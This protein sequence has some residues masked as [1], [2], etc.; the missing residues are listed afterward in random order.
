MTEE[1]FFEWLDPEEEIEKPKKKKKSEK[2]PI[3]ATKGV[4]A[5]YFGYKYDIPVDQKEHTHRH[6]YT[7]E[8]DF[9]L[10][11]YLYPEPLSKVEK[12]KLLDDLVD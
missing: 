4:V 8:D 11:D 9:Y 10:S 3:S 6:N 5:R 12:I 7:T 1:E 2:V